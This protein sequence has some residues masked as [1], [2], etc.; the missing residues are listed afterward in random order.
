MGM[1]YLVR[2]GETYWNAEGRIQGQKQTDLTPKG[3]EQSKW[4]ADYFKYKAIDRIVCSGLVRSQKTAK[5]INTYH[6]LQLDINPKINECSWGKWEGL[7]HAEVRERYPDEYNS[8]KE[9]IWYFCPQN[10]E[11]YDDLFDRLYPVASEFATMAVTENLLVVSHAMVNKVL[12]GIFLDLPAEEI[13]KIAYPND[14]VYLISRCS[15]E[16]TVKHI[17]TE[18][19]DVVEGYLKSIEI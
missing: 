8:R 1:I 5:Q 16:W 12:L 4:L 11:S 13:V 18:S 3:I 17:H 6:N 9:D 7:T 14:T 2:H 19:N 15:N 10:G